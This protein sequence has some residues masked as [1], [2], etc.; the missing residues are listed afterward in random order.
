MHLEQHLEVY[1]QEH[2]ELGHGQ[3]RLS[4]AG[5]QLVFGW[6]EVIELGWPLASSRLARGDQSR[7][8]FS[9]LLARWT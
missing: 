8:G 5:S 7:L 9:W 3:R 2:F 6:L 1:V 4:W